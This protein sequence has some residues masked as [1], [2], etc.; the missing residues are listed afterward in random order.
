MTNSNFQAPLDRP[1]TIHDKITQKIP[2]KITEM[3]QARDRAAAVPGTRVSGPRG[4]LLTVAEAKERAEA[5]RMVVELEE[6]DG[7]ERHRRVS[8]TSKVSLLLVVVV[9][10]FPIM[11]WL[12]AAVF[13]VDWSSL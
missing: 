2:Q 12:A 13:N 3:N 9:I 5:F 4:Q 6:A 8:L 10:D 11:L 1:P 7:S